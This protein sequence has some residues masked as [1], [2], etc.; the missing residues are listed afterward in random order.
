MTDVPRTSDPRRW[1]RDLRRIGT[2]LLR[3]DWHLEG[4]LPSAERKSIIKSLRQELA[5]GPR[6]LAKALSDL[7][8]PQVLASHYAD[9]SERRPLWSIGIIT[10]GNRPSPRRRPWVSAGPAD[11]HGSLFRQPSPS[12]HS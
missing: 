8:P 12:S 2:Y 6:N 11:G 1:I 10:G 7:E 5:A 9:E 3:L 4:S